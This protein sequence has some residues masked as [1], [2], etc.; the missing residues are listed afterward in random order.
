MISQP[1][2]YSHF[3]LIILP[4]RGRPVH[5]RMLSNIS[6][7]HLLEG[8]SSLLRQLWQPKTPPNIPWGTKSPI[9][10]NHCSKS[11]VFGARLSRTAVIILGLPEWSPHLTILN[12]TTSTKSL[13]PCKVT[14][15]QVLGIR[16]WI[17]LEGDIIQPRAICY[18]SPEF[19]VCLT[20]IYPIPSS[21]K[22]SSCNS[23]AQ[24][25]KFI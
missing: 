9:V 1:Q 14:Y 19:H 21:P 2:H 25:Q 8:A 6:D 23:I 10:K 3:C 13:L 7:L 16:M 12:L 5:C 18:L 24:V 20:C 22:L 17:S 4:C 11:L 15:S